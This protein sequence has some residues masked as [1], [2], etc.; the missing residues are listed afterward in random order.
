MGEQIPAFLGSNAFHVCSSHFV[1]FRA[2]WTQGGHRLR[3]VTAPRHVK[4][5]EKAPARFTATR[6]PTLPPGTHTDPGQPGLQLRVREK[7]GAGA[8]RSWLLR[9]KFKGEE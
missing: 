8:S 7:V 4:R 2:E 5:T 9:F 1:Q 6:V 3:S